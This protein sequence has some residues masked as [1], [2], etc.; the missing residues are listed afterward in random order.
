MNPFLITYI[1]AT[2]LAML[3]TLLISCAASSRLKEKYPTKPHLRKIS[4]SEKIIGYLKWIAV[5]IIP[6]FHV[7]VI[8]VALAYSDTIIE[9]TVATIESN[10]IK[11]EN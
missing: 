11:E 5:C 9:R 4:A 10:I 8:A 6:V 2:A 3:L 7:L 1:I